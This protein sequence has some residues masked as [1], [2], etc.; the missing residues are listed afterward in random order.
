MSKFQLVLFDIGE[1]IVKWRDTWLYHAV[2]EKFDV[3]EKTLTAECEKEIVNLHTGK[4]LENEF[5]KKIG[6]K[7]NSIELQKVKKSLIYDTFKEKAKLNTPILKMVKT[8]QENEIKVG[9]LSNLEKTTHAIL[10]EF[11]ILDRFEFQFYSHKIG[12][13]K[14]D[15][16]LFKY[17]LDNMPF[18]SSEIFFIDDKISNVKTAN[19]IGIKSIK[20]Q[21]AEKLKQDLKKYKIL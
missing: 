14:P 12:F 4:I 17:V 8:I 2:S 19:S 9:V 10:E 7:V 16:R 13:A 21:N 20:Y 18:E 6:K 15:K 1:V 3:S 11:G 5:W